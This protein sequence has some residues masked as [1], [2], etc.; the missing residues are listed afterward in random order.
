MRILELLSTQGAL[1]LEDIAK[2]T[3]IPR[4][5]VFRLLNTFEALGYVEREPIHGVDHW[6]L[7]LKLLCL[8]NS[9]L[10]RLDIRKEVRRIMEDL[11]DRTD[12]FVQL[13][14]FYQGKVMYIDHVKRLKP[15]AMYAELGSQLPINVSAA[16]MVLAAALDDK[17]LDQLLEEETFP[18]H[19]PKTPTKSN[20]LRK[21]LKKVRLQG[22]AVDDQQYAIGIRCISAPIFNHNGHVIAAI[23]ITGSLLSMTDE[24]IDTLVGQVKAA[25]EE[26][27][28]KMGYTT[29]LASLRFEA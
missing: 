13:G 6:L 19:T 25:A 26:A 17:E 2:E 12:E 22:F 11:A 3:R 4:T 1:P 18:K 9:K 21:M 10:S 7:G 15:L 16:G 28:K 24:R 20:E 8:T 5:S 27:S 23:N 14:V 29:G